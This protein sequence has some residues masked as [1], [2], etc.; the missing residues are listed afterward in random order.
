MIQPNKNP[1][2]QNESGVFLFCMDTHFH[3]QKMVCKSILV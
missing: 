1:A 2:S 3:V